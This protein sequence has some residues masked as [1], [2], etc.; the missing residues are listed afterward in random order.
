MDSRHALKALA[1]EMASVQGETDDVKDKQR[2]ETEAGR[3]ARVGPSA[4]TPHSRTTSTKRTC[5]E[6]RIYRASH[7]FGLARPS[8]PA[9]SNSLAEELSDPAEAEAAATDSEQATPSK[10]TYFKPHLLTHEFVQIRKQGEQSPKTKEEHMATS[11]TASTKSW[12][13]GD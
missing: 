12:L 9:D 6:P 11:R 1:S 3:H 7:R 2:R 10:V 13:N 4:G 8:R 5:R